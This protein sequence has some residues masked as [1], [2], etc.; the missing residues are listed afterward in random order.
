MT[1]QKAALDARLGRKN[2]SLRRERFNGR[3]ATK[4]MTCVGDVHGSRAYSAKRFAQVRPTT[5]L[6]LSGKTLLGRMTTYQR[7][8]VFA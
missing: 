4:M 2:V 8:S 1:F 3:K 5:H 7:G 6:L